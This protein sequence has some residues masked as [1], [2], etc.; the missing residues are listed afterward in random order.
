VGVAAGLGAG[1]TLALWPRPPSPACQALCPGGHA[2]VTT[3][4]RTYHRMDPDP[5]DALDLL[6]DNLEDF[7]CGPCEIAV[8][9]EDGVT[10]RDHDRGIPGPPP[11]YS[12]ERYPNDHTRVGKDGVSRDGRERE[13]DR[14]RSRR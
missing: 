7:G 8:T 11:T 5:P 13:R 3:S 9:H 10:F 2:D 14:L 1:L 12:V 6:E 4:S